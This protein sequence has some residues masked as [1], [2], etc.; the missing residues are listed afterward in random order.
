MAFSMVGNAVGIL[1]GWGGGGS[2]SRVRAAD[3]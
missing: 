1:R 3:H 2:W